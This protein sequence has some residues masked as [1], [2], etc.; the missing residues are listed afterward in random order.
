MKTSFINFEDCQSGS[1]MDE[2]V[3]RL[4]NFKTG[5]TYVDIG[6]QHSYYHNNTYYL[7]HRL[8]WRGIS[9]EIEDQWNASY[10]E[11]PDHK[12]IN[13]D[14][15]KVDYN[16]EFKNFNMPD[17]IDF[18]SIDIDN[19]SAEFLNLVLP[20]HYRF[21]VIG[22]EHDAYL[23]GDKYRS[24]QRYMLKHYGYDLTCADVFV[25]SPILDSAPFED[26]YLDTEHFSYEAINKLKVHGA[27]GDDIVNKLK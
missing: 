24:Q 21:K 13:A 25:R 6:S 22:I 26:W 11:R 5:G 1:C 16:K 3:A 23:Y 14:A 17:V 18:L 20:Y 9:V 4:F 10:N 27:Y 19:E 12:H 2:F 15:L 8:K 7:N